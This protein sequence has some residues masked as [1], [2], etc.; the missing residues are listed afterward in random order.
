MRIVADV[1]GPGHLHMAY[2]RDPDD[3]TVHELFAWEYNS[4][5]VPARLFKAARSSDGESMSASVQ[6]IVR[7]ETVDEPDLGVFQV[8]LPSFHS[9]FDKRPENP[10]EIHGGE[11]VAV[12][13]AAEEERREG[14][15]F[16]QFVFRWL[17]IL[18][19]IV[20]ILAFIWFR[21]NPRVSG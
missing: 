16:T 14:S 9:I 1:A 6:F 17:L 5:G 21:K 7:A 18:S 12:Y 10:V 19:L 20:P 15:T 8:D 2:V 13:D 4:A 11:V 3:G